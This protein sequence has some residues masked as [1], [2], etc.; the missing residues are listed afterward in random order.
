MR[1]ARLAAPVINDTPDYK[2]EIGKGIK[3]A[4]GKD[5]T[6]VA[7]GLMVI[8]VFGVL[9]VCNFLFDENTV[10][11]IPTGAVVGIGYAVIFVFAIIAYALCRILYKK[12]LS[13]FAFKGILGKME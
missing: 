6:I 7:T 11:P 4:E 10:V 2:F 3:M 12:D 1:F 5:V 8:A 13:K 9:G